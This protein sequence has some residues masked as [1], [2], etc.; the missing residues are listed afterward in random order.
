MFELQLGLLCYILGQGAL[1][2]SSRCINVY[3]KFNAT[4]QPFR[5]LSSRPGGSGKT[6]S[7]FCTLETR[8]EH[9]PDRPIASNSDL[10]HRHSSSTYIHCIYLLLFKSFIKCCVVCSKHKYNIKPSLWKKI[11][12]MVIYNIS[13]FAHLI[14]QFVHNLQRKK[15]GLNLN[16]KL[17]LRGLFNKI[18]YRNVF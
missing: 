7:H 18:T 11:T 17:K 15:S 1:P 16:F 2:L 14:L 9:C 5:G 8:N 6:P 4:G 13:T 10:S 3:C 12:T